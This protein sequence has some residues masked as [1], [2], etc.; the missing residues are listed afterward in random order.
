MFSLQGVRLAKYFEAKVRS[1]TRF[2]IPADRH[3]GMV[4]FRV[5]VSQRV[6]INAN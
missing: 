5:K 2:E 4:V 3:L 1:D 6:Q